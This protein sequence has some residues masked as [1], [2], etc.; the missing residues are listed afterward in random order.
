MT[1]AAER[2]TTPRGGAAASALAWLGLGILALAGLWLLIGAWEEGLSGGRDF[3]QDYAAIVKIGQGRDPYEPYND[4]TQE[5]FGGPPHRGPLYSFHAPSSLP[6]LIWLL[7]VARVWGYPGA[8]LAW[9][10]VSL[11]ALW[12]VCWLT[13]RALGMPRPA[14]AGLLAALA[15]VT[16]PSIREC[17]EEGQLNVAVVAGMVGCW[18]F[19]RTG[20]SGIGGLLLGAAFALKPIPGLFFAYYAWRRDWR[21]L[22]AAVATVAVLSLV[23]VGLSGL[24]GARLWATV[25]YPSHAEVWPGYPDNSSI[26]G[27]FTRIFGPSEWRPRPRFPVAYLSMLLWAAGGGLLTLGA[28]LAARA[29]GRGASPGS[30]GARHLGLLRPAPLPRD[31][32]RGDLEIAVLTV[33]TLLVTPIVWPHY[34]VVLVMPVAVVAAYLGRRMLGRPAGVASRCLSTD[35]DPG[36][37][38]TGAGPPT[39]MPDRRR[40]LMPAIAL[41]VLGLAVAVLATA[42]YVEPFRGVGGQQLAALLAVYGASLAALGWSARDQGR[43]ANPAATT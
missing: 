29:G 43:V 38:P 16:L 25:N 15:L 9:G 3:V 33:L 18:A 26:R 8:L 32:P 36:L 1:L 19:R 39:P 6:L 41:L 12:I 17:F 28:L 7:P 34:Y 21:L 24:E 30:L 5:L 4:V 40:Q 13:L 42:H 20:H 22:V 37:A 31:D 2:S 23:G 14:V 11:A 35:F 10:V 27:F